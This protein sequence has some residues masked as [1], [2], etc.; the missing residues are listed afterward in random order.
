MPKL[1][2]ANVDRRK[3]IPMKEQAP[4]ERKKNFDEVALGYT[5]EEAANEAKRCL[6][7]DSPTCVEGCPVGIDIPKFVKE[8]ADGKYEEAAKTLKDKNN[9]PAVCGRVCPQESQCEKKCILGMKWK[10]LAI[11]RLERFA[12]DSEKTVTK[13]D[14]KPNGKK[15]AVVGS[16]PAGLTA[17]A[18]LAQD[19]ISGH[20]LRGVT[21]A[22]RSARLRY[23]GVQAAQGHRGKRGRIHQGPGRRGQAEPG[24]RQDHHHRR[25]YS[26]PDIWPSSSEAAQGCPRSCTYRA[27]T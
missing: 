4:E 8:I 9:L 13:A 24:G 23:P 5:A 19:G 1:P 22:R 7:C 25:D 20:D 16:G 21:Q 3:R 14:I 10:P 18:D 27:R 17:A 2:T 6:E 15:V 11:G 26:H 12:A